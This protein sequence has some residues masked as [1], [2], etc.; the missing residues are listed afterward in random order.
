MPPVIDKDRCIQCGKCVEVCQM[1]VFFGSNEKDIPV[2][3]YPEECW[4]CYACGLE[5]PKDA[6]R[7]EIPLPMMVGFR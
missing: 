2:I 5:C 3:T 7:L 1:D 4:H 6:I